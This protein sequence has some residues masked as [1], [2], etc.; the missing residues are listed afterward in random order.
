MVEKLK[1][2][3][4][5]ESFKRLGY[6]IIDLLTHHLEEAQNEKIPV[7][8]WQEPSSQLDFWKNYTLGNK[9]PSSLFKEIIGKSIHIHHPKYMGH[10]VCPPAPVAA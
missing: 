1:Q 2:V 4:D 10:Q 9:P 6:E 8:T 7:M 3:Y 5:P